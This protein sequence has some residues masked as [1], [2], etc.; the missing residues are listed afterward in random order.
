MEATSTCSDGIDVN[1]DDPLYN[2]DGLA[3]VSTG[4][5]HHLEQS[6]DSPQRWKLL[7]GNETIDEFTR[8]VVFRGVCR[9]TSSDDITGITDTNGT[10][11]TC[12]INGGV[13]NAD[14]K[15]VT[16]TASWTE[17]GRSHEVELVT[18]LTNWNQ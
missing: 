6:T 8:S 1:T 13:Y 11:T 18:Y 14:T 12:V 7:T 3:V 15:E 4:A 10:T 9:D 17:R 5:V 2:D 16:V